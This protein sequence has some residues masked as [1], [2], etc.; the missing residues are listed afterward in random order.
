MRYVPNPGNAGDA[1]IAAATFQFFDRIGITPRRSRARDI[2]RGDVAIYGGGGNL[3]PEYRDCSNFL[4]RCLAVD[5]G[6]AIVLPQ[7]IRGHDDLL[8]RLDGRFTLVSRDARG[9]DWIRRKAPRAGALLAPDMALGLDVPALFERCASLPGRIGFLRRLVASSSVDSYLRWRRRLRRIRPDGDGVLRIYRSD[10]EAPE[11][12]RGAVENDLP[13]LY[14]AGGSREESEWI[15]RDML[16][17]LGGARTI[18][19]NRLHVAIGGTLLRRRVFLSDNSYGKNSAVF[20]AFPD[21]FRTVTWSDQAV[22][23]AT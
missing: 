7:T 6:R 18:F 21:A 4:E 5:V 9:L 16:T 13:G 3:V 17:V 19:T 23:A 2:A 14:H 1:L 11:G 20:G 15:A 8:A 12:L 10:C 22:P